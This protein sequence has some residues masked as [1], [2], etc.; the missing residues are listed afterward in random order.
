MRRVIHFTSDGVRPDGDSVLRRQ[1]IPASAA[2]SV[3]VAALLDAAQAAFDAHARP[4]A[5]LE[6]VSYAEFADVYGADEVSE[7]RTPLGD[8]SPRAQALALFAGTLGAGVDAEIRRLF[9][10]GDAALGCMLDAVAGAA[11]ERLADAAAQRFLESLTPHQAQRLYVL[12]YS[13]GY[14]GWNV[15][16]QSALF[17]KLHPGAIGIHLTDTCL[18][19]PVKSVSGVLVAAPREEHRFRPDYPFCDRCGT[20]DCLPRMRS[21]R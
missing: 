4:V 14:C 8:V 1:G 20:R 11:T 3:Q 18:M 15:C 19:Q 13:P 6:D 17:A 10:A 9:A 21:V 2:V 16:G 5:I 12:P 7:P